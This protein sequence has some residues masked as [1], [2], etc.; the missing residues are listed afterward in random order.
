MGA[1]LR[2]AGSKSLLFCVPDTYSNPIKF[3]TPKPLQAKNEKQWELS[4]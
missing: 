2:T 3:F 1:R 4:I